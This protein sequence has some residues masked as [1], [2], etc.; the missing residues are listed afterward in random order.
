MTNTP[1][2]VQSHREDPPVHWTPFSF[3]QYLESREGKVWR[4]DDTV[5]LLHRAKEIDNLIEQL[6]RA[7]GVQI[8]Q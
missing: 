7:A 4:H 1:G 8:V 3:R 2:P 5:R 6:M